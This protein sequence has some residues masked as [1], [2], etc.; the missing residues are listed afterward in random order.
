MIIRG[1][2]QNS[3]QRSAVLDSTKKTTRSENTENK[4]DR[5]RYD[6]DL[7]QE[8]WDAIKAEVDCP[9]TGRGRRRTV[10]VREVLNAIFYN[11]RT[12]CQW[13]LLPHDFPNFSTV[14]Y[15]F[16]K[17]TKNGVFLHINAMLRRRIRTQMGR[18]P[19][20]SAAIIDSQSVKTTAVGG[21]DI[22][23]DGGKLTKGRK[24][25]ILVDTEGLLITVKVHSANIADNTGAKQV[26]EAARP[27]CPRLQNVWA[28]QGYR[29]ELITW[30]SEQGAWD[31]EIVQRIDGQQG[32]V[33]LPRRWVVERSLA[34]YSRNRGLSK[35]YEYYPESSESMVY[36]ASIRLMLRR[37]SNQET[38]KKIINH[39]A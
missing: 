12:G 23:F 8:E 5:Q 2:Y 14:Y 13:K 1:V 15:Y 28:D 38:T 27:V 21:P 30:T 11:V 32:F 19:D 37:I 18:D 25:H 26:F 6:T 35:D 36:L 22:G 10:D 20:P 39:A 34:W 29:G 3:Q 16:R 4:S 24:R 9:Q 31:R 17:W 33:V 7:S